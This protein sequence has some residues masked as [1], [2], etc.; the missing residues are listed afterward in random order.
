MRIGLTNG[1]KKYAINNF[2]GSENR[3]K[4]FECWHGEEFKIWKRFEG[5]FRSCSKQ[6]KCNPVLFTKLVHI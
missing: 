2:I 4:M 3:N 5:Y 6:V 1:S